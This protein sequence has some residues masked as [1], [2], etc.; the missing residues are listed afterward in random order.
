MLNAHLCC[1]WAMARR[2]AATLMRERL[3][4][5]A[6]GAAVVVTGDFNAPTGGTVYDEL[7]GPG[8]PH[9][10][11]VLEDAGVG[12]SSRRIDWILCSEHFDVAAAGVD[13]RR[14]LGRA[15]SDHWPVTAE[16]RWRPPGRSA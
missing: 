9:L 15:G 14:H 8:G 7:L 6:A 4:Q 12:C 11:E 10:R 3:T 16:L 1:F 5:L 13:R 2:R